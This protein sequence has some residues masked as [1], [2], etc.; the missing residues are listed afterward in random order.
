M[1]SLFQI[2]NDTHIII[3]SPY[4]PFFKDLVWVTLRL[5]VLRN[6]D[7]RWTLGMPI[8]QI[9]YPIHTEGA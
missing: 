2:K 5:N 3:L 7:L 1:F 6:I 4:K 8:K 9:T